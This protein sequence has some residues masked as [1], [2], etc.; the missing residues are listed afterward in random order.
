MKNDIYS[1][2]TIW[3]NAPS[4]MCILKDADHKYVFAN[5]AYR[6]LIGKI[7]FL[8]QTVKEV[9]PEI[10]S[11]GFIG[12]L[13][14]V[15]TTGEPYHGEE[16]P[17]VVNL[18]N[19]P[20]KYFLDF[21][22]QPLTDEN[23]KVYGIFVLVNNITK[24]VELRKDKEVLL[25]E[26][27]HRVKNNLALIMGLVDMQAQEIDHEECL[28]LFRNTRKRVGT[29]SKVHELI[30]NQHDLKKVPVHE[31]LEKLTAQYID[32]HNPKI[33]V[34]DRFNEFYVNINQAIPLGLICNE[35]LGWFK[36]RLNNQEI[37]IG[38]EMEHMPEVDLIFT[39]DNAGDTLTK[40]QFLWDNNSFEGRLINI[41]TMQLKAGVEV[42]QIHDAFVVHIKFDK[43]DIAGSGANRFL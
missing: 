12:I 19:E 22:Y 32:H 30:F 20:H 10:V 21:I 39:I 43:M 36:T 5:K 40:E 11:Q 26:L 2:D 35:M 25:E 31:L 41:L 4:P 18:H 14:K 42:Q 37:R 16:I 9:L 34:S 24:Q 7:N 1:R 17:I 8:N 27:H 23:D 13:D 15:Y 6:E 3:E 38:S 29:F 28:L 33:T